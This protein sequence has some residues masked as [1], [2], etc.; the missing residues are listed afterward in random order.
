[1][2]QIRRFNE[3]DSAKGSTIVTHFDL[4]SAAVGLENIKT[5]HPGSTYRVFRMTEVEI[6]I[7]KKYEVRAV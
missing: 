3:N 2:Y 4:E 1:M 7:T 5:L 6:I